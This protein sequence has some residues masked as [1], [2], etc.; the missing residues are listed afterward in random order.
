MR[1]NKKSFLKECALYIKG[2][3]S[4]VKISGNKNDVALVANVL[5]ESRKFYLALESG[6]LKA[7][8]PQLNK[9]RAASNALKKRTGYVWPL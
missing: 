4:E 2:D 7:A 3:I 1:D 6:N 5:S 8:L 9:K